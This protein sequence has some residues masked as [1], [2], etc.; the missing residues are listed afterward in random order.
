MSVNNIYCSNCGKKGHLFKNCKFPIISFGIICIKLENIN[1]NKLLLNAKNL[2]DNSLVQNNENNINY[3]ELPFLTEKEYNKKIK[4][5]MIRR[6]NSFTYIDFMRGKYNTYDIDYLFN[7]FNL[8]TITELN[9]LREKTFDELWEDLWN[10]KLPNNIYKV[11]YN[12]SKN[13]FNELKKGKIIN[14]YNIPINISIDYIIKHNYTKWKEPE[15]GFPKG[16]RNYKE[17]EYNCAIR[18]FIEET[19]FKENEIELINIEPLIELFIGSNGVKYKHKYFIAQSIPKKKVKI[20]INNKYQLNEISDIKWMNFNEA[21]NNIREY[22]LEKK[23]ILNNIYNLLKM[24]V[25][26]NNI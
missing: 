12:N 1:I 26:R 11:E 18:E 15:W 10:I 24:L 25:V 17:T 9:N 2:I 16:R 4:F 21:K 3:N 8:M 7:L 5:V 20:D 14:I 19:N 13:K 23:N 22:N 6:K